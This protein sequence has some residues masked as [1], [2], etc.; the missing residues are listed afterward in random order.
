MTIITLA[1]DFHGTETNLPATLEQGADY[2][3]ARVSGYGLMMAQRDLCGMD[4][5]SCSECTTG[6]TPDGRVWTVFEQ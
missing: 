6:T 5:C 1:N 3:V 4:D 2:R